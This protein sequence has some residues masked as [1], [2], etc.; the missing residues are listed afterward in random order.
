[1]SNAPKSERFYRSTAIS[2]SNKSNSAN[3]L[4]SK[5]HTMVADNTAAA[6]S[7]NFE[8][9]AKEQNTLKDEFNKLTEKLKKT[10]VV[11]SAANPNALQKSIEQAPGILDA[12]E[13][14]LRE[15]DAKKITETQIA[16]QRSLEQLLSLMMN[17]DWAA[18][19]GLMTIVLLVAWNAIPIKKTSPRTRP[20]VCH[21]V[22]HTADDHL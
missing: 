18:K 3:W 19:I 16:A 8:P 9:I 10:K 11:S 2:T 22:S 21:R 12:A 15:G 17:H 14:A 7:A 6:L 20:F 1:M 4:P 5:F 13:N